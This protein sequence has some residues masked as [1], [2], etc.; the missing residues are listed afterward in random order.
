MLPT[1]PLHGGEYRT[2]YERFTMSEIIKGTY[3]GETI[4]W[5]PGYGYR[6]DTLA[7]FRTMD[8]LRQH[9]DARMESARAAY[10]AIPE[11]AYWETLASDAR[12]K[13]RLLLNTPEYEHF[14]NAAQLAYAMR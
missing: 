8:E 13:Y 12:R 3:G 11:N 10:M 6:G 5:I 1:N 4:Y 2:H 14:K 7:T 9:I